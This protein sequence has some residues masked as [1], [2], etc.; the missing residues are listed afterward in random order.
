M[1]WNNKEFSNL[2]ICHGKEELKKEF[3]IEDSLN[4]INK[5]VKYDFLILV[6]F[7]RNATLMATK[8]IRQ[9]NEFMDKMDF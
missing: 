3:Q 2:T 5:L 4:L 7:R 9:N 8:D 1:N 6:Q